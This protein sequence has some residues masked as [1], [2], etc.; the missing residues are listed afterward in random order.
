MEHGYMKWMRGTVGK[1]KDSPGCMAMI[2]L[3][4]FSDQFLFNHLFKELGTIFQ[5]K[6]LYDLNM[7]FKLKVIQSS[8][9]QIVATE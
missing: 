5:G 9:M 3:V 7:I 1:P 2:S 4:S 6:I 8:L